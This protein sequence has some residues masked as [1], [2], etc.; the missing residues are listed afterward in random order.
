LSGRAP[1]ALAPMRETRIVNVGETRARG[2]GERTFRRGGGGGAGAAVVVGALATVAG[3]VVVRPL[4][5]EWLE[6]QA[7]IPSANAEVVSTEP[8]SR[9]ALI[10]ET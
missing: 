7:V 6:P 2:R 3:L 5:E 4:L 8:V 1:A 9:S 10:S